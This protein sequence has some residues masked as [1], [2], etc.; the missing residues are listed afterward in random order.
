M[1]GIV[2]EEVPDNH[3]DLLAIAVL[4]A[5]GVIG[6]NEY[7][8]PV[9]VHECEVCGREYTLC[10]PTWPDTTCGEPGVCSSY[11][12]SRDPTCFFAPDDPDLIEGD[13]DG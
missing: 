5:G 7:G 11:D 13:R 9:S 6:F 4:E 2:R 8:T 10:P 3:F 1:T 12:P